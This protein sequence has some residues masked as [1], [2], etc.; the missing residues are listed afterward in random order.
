MSGVEN[1]RVS[2]WMAM[3]GA[4]ADNTQTMQHKA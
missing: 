4:K 3:H 1:Y 2:N